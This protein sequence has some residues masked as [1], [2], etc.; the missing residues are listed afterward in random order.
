MNQK[1]RKMRAKHYELKK[2]M[3][4]HCQVL[5]STLINIKYG[6]DLFTYF[7]T[8]KPKPKNYFQTPIITNKY[9]SKLKIKAVSGN[10]GLAGTTLIVDVEKIQSS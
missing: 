4:L 8:N 3:L 1:E 2:F 6:T 9:Y 5:N 7:A 10:T